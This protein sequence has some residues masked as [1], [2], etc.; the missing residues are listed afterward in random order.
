MVRPFWW[1][2][3]FPATRLNETYRVVN[4]PTG[5]WIVQ[6]FRAGL[7]LDTYS[8]TERSQLIELAP[9]DPKAAEA[10]STLRMMTQGR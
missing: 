7:W 5:Q 2:G 4:G 10:L 8:T 9:T 6:E 1:S 3:R